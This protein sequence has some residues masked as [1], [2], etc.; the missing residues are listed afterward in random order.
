M[1]RSDR[2][3]HRAATFDPILKDGETYPGAPVRLSPSW[4]APVPTRAPGP[5]ARTEIVLARSSEGDSGWAGYGPFHASR[6]Q[7]LAD[8]IDR[9]W[10]WL[11]SG[12]LMLGM[13]KAPAIVDL[14]RSIWA[15][16]GG[17]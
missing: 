14:L 12:A 9:A 15:T 3:D 4:R 11:L 6:A 13:V 5:R 2:S 1:N 8:W 7:R 16:G 17:G 10:P